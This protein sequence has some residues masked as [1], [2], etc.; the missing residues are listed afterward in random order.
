MPFS[1]ASPH[2][3]SSWPR[4]DSPGPHTGDDRAREGIP[5]PRER[6]RTLPLEEPGTRKALAW[7][8][9]H[10]HAPGDDRLGTTIER[11][12]SFCDPGLSTEAGGKIISPA[13]DDEPGSPEPASDANVE[14]P[15]LQPFMLPVSGREVRPQPTTIG[16]KDVANPVAHGVPAERLRLARPRRARRCPEGSAQATPIAA[17]DGREEPHDETRRCPW[18]ASGLK[19]GGIPGNE[20]PRRWLGCRRTAPV[21]RPRSSCSRENEE[22]HATDGNPATHSGTGMLL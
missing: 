19:L 5:T 21:H 6:A 16:D 11:H 15:K 17:V 22:E 18:T 14:I 4:R 20:D 12:L 8:H 3:E 2:T 10:A 9:L 7:G 1:K 13:N